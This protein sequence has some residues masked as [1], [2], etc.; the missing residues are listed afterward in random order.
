MGLR[1]LRNLFPLLFNLQES[2]GLRS[3]DL[4][5]A[6]GS[7]LG[8]TPSCLYVTNRSNFGFW[9][10]R[11]TVVLDMLVKNKVEER[12]DKVNASLSSILRHISTNL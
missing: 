9:H 6:L 11:E 10:K 2:M 4:G 8:D 3:L 1:F 7:F 12:L 5:L